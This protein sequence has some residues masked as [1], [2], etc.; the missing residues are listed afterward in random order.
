MNPYPSIFAPRGLCMR[1][2]TE[3]TNQRLSNHPM[4]YSCSSATPEI[5][6]ECMHGI[7]QE[8]KEE[9]A[10]MRLGDDA[11][12]GKTCTEK[13]KRRLCFGLSRPG[14][15]RNDCMKGSPITQ[16]RFQLLCPRA[17]YRCE[18]VTTLNNLWTPTWL[19]LVG[20]RFPTMARRL[21]R[22]PAP[23]PSWPTGRGHENQPA[24][25]RNDTQQ[26]ASPDLMLSDHPDTWSSYAIPTLTPLVHG[27]RPSP[28]AHNL[29]T[30]IVAFFSLATSLF[31][32][33]VCLPPCANLL[34]ENGTYITCSQWSRR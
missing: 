31:I 16:A 2:A 10:C 19:V 4:H 24:V 26:P 6:K 9:H 14:R 27:A 30:V 33:F 3:P 25:A 13:N 12:E 28:A 18:I 11:G 5:Q 15:A 17:T 32:S 29:F 7:V 1:H 23:R 22:H 8:E 20:R 21:P 34:F